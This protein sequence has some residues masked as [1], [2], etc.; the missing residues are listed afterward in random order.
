MKDNEIAELKAVIQ[1]HMQ[2]ME[3]MSS[4]IRHHETV[5]RQLHNTVQELKVCLSSMGYV[6]VG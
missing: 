6:T 2:T 3:E 4:K 1:A 5:R